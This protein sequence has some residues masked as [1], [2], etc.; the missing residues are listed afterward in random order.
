M[1]F[2]YHMYGQTIGTII[3][4]LKTSGTLRPVWIKSR[5]QS[6]KWW[7]ANVYLNNQQKYQ[8]CHFRYSFVRYTNIAAMSLSFHSLR[9]YH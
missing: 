2:M 9:N 4:Y 6:N 8:V 5:N 7:K 3:V 1:T